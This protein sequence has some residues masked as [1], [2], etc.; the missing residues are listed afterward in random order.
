MS[1]PV[2]IYDGTCGFCK[3]WVLRLDSIT[4]GGFEYRP[5]QEA[6]TDYPDIPQ[7]DFAIAAQLIDGNKTHH[8][9]ARAMLGALALGNGPKWPLHAYENMPG[10]QSAVDL[11]Y[12]CIARN[13]SMF[14]A[15]DRFLW[16]K[17][18]T[19]EPPE[20]S[21]AQWI[22]GP[23]TGL[24]FFYFGCTFIPRWDSLFGWYYWAVLANL[25]GGPLLAAAYGFK[26]RNIFRILGRLLII[27]A[28]A[29]PVNSLAIF[30]FT[31]LHIK[32]SLWATIMAP[33]AL[34]ALFF[35]APCVQKITSRFSR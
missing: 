8:S 7:Q 22:L 21:T 17:E 16:G 4:S 14:S 1:R 30:G 2:L 6:A 20:I 34:M 19:P 12:S 31:R 27:L 5:Y 28:A 23:L 10:L 26:L 9:G 24:A 18:A 35:L 25:T 33:I 13:R 15:V 32:W 3:R 11:L 29:A